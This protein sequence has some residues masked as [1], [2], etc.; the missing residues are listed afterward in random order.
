MNEARP[1]YRTRSSALVSLVMPVW[2]PRAEWLRAAVDS[3]LAQ[4]GC[5]VELIVVDDGCDPPVSR[6]LED[7]EDERLRLIRVPHGRVSRARNAGIAEARGD[8]LRFVDCDDVIVSDSTAHLLSLAGESDG[9]VTYG[10]TVICDEHLRP[11][12]TIATPLEGRVA[13]DC[14]LNRFD[15]TIHS[16]LFPRRVVD[17]IGPWEPSIHVS[18]D[19]DYALRAFE[20]AQVRG[21][22]R[23]ATYYR[24]HP[25]MNSRDVARGI[26]GYRLV[27]E[28]Y[29]ER[30]PE[31][32]ESALRRRAEMRFHLFAAVQLATKLRRYRE[33][34]QHL[35]RAFALDPAGM[36]KTLPRHA[37]M[38]LLPAVGRGRR[39]LGRIRTGP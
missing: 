36:I 38:P 7:V 35:R 4:S 18:Q 22:D 16:L 26:E 28:R 15:T 13:E 31:Q 37:A 39:L 32:R 3:A 11:V 2:N 1:S 17:A 5:T 6:L 27:V 14:L 8:Y 12:S 21:D 24:T 20:Y 23:V 29:F 25:G 19:W 30:N 33:A 9:V 34:A 10:A